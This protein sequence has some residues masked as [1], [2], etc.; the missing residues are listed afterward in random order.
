VN[1]RDGQIPVT[2]NNLTF[3]GSAPQ[4]E[5]NQ[6]LSMKTKIIA[7]ATLVAGFFMVFSLGN[8]AMGDS[9]GAP[10]GRTGSP[11][12]G[13]TTC[14]N[15]CHTG[16]AV[17]PVAGWITSNIP[18]TGYVPGTTYSITATATYTGRVKFG[19]E[20]SPQDP[21]GN[22]IG[23][24]AITSAQTQLVASGKYITHTSSGT[25][26][27]NSKSW[28]F[29]WTAPPSGT[30][31][32]TFYGAFNCTNNN[33]NSSGDL[34]Y[35]STLPVAEAV[36]NGIDCGIYSVATPGPTACD[37]VITPVVKLQNYGSTTLTDAD[38]NYFIDA[39]TPSVYHWTGSLATAASQMVTL[40]SLTVT[41][42]GTHTFT[43]STS[44]PNASS[45]IVP[46]NDVHTSTF[47]LVFTGLTLPFSE[48]F[49]GTTFPP[50]GWM[51]NNP[52]GATTWSRVT[53]AHFSGTAS[54]KMDNYNYNGVGQKDDLITPPLDLT[55]DPNPNLTFEVAYRLYT[56]PTANPHYSDTLTVS[57]STDCGSTWT[58]LYNKYGTN[59]TTATPAYSTSAFTPTTAQWRQESISLL[60]Y[61]GCTKAYIKFTNTTS[62]EN[63]LY[64]DAIYI[65]GPAAIND[66]A[67]TE[68]SLTLF[69]NPS[70]DGNI[71]M[72]YELSERSSISYEIFNL[73]G[74]SVYRQDEGMKDEGKYAENISIADLPEG[75]YL[76]RL[77]VGG[78]MVTRRFNVVK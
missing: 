3:T 35:T 49:D 66:P 65:N 70:T 60:P 26:G 17:T 33:N 61:Q 7:A 16:S 75:V 56:N 6:F 29:N 31:A 55:S 18:G 40:P 11:G 58:V 76:L 5:L 24:L 1:F 37:S 73:G 25:S 44:N 30:G 48:G 59:L 22:K 46:T 51:R 41:V 28:T 54:A 77:N 42:A 36:P 50:A 53:N 64:L 63:N 21:A 47:N 68:A 74:Q 39:N 45:D 23:T 4:V 12:D 13:N 19:F 69:P 57:I 8:I 9:N 52:D 20:V 78:K 67:A 2:T 72:N 43:A 38:I 71:N 27:T 34:I 10:A 14:A 32:F 15:S 62:Y